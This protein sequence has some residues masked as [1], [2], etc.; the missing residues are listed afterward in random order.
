[1]NGKSDIISITAAIGAALVIALFIWAFVGGTVG[2]H[3]A[4]ISRPRRNSSRLRQ[5]EAEAAKL[6]ETGAVHS[7]NVEFNRVRI[8]PIVW[9]QLDLATKQQ[10]V[11]FFSAYFE[12]ADSTGR[13]EILSNRN[14][15]ALATLNLGGMKILK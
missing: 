8:D 3:H 12:A 5:Y 6:I 14:D 1:M 10:T 11:R 9:S 2:D 13:V 7:I 4:S 15:T